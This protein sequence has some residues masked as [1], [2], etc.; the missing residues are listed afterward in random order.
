M[1]GLLDH[2]HD[3]EEYNFTSGGKLIGEGACSDVYGLNDQYAVK[4]IHKEDSLIDCETVTQVA[5]TQAVPDSPFILKP[6]N[7]FNLNIHVEI[8]MPRAVQS[9]RCWCDRLTWPQLKS[10]SGDIRRMMYCIVQALCIFHDRD[11]VHMD[12]KPDNMLIM[13]DGTAVL[14]D[15]DVSIP[16]IRMTAYNKISYTSHYR[17]PE[18]WLNQNISLKSDVWA[19]GV[20][21]LHVY[22]LSYPFG[23]ECDDGHSMM[24]MFVRLIGLPPLDMRIEGMENYDQIEM[25][26]LN[27]YIP[28]APDD[29]IDLISQCLR[30][31]PEERLSFR[32]ILQHSYFKSVNLVVPPITPVIEDDIS[33]ISSRMNDKQRTILFSWLYELMT[34][35]DMDTLQYGMACQL[36]D[37]YISHFI[38]I[39]ESQLVGVLMV[40]FVGCITPPFISMS[41]ED[42]I[43]YTDKSYSI[44][45]IC[46]MSNK[47]LS[48]I[49]FKLIVES[50]H[51]KMYDLLTSSPQLLSSIVY[52]DIVPLINLMYMS[53]LSRHNTPMQNAQA[54]L[55]LIRDPYSNEPL[56]SSLILLHNDERIVINKKSIPMHLINQSKCD[57]SIDC[58]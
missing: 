54:L 38:V 14:C 9:I 53:P 33:I 58:I 49:K 56:R 40:Y 32:E 31:R 26:G 34:E 17:P 12:V 30:W 45:E 39:R 57:T 4:I 2:T 27:W 15:F 13:E 41:I 35:I 29:A 20:S 22:R 43:Y 24:K 8:V 51:V 28:N 42:L 6:L 36:I 37:E 10:S 23:G 5:I 46:S 7:V 18:V 25:K 52:S 44:D 48:N 16:Y 55:S 1:K 3:R 47:I 50:I 21:L 11:I 19:F